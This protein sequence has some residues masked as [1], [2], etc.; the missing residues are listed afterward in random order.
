MIP[1]EKYRLLAKQLPRR[2]G[3]QFEK[4][5]PT[6]SPMAIDLLRKLLTFDASKRITVEEALRHPFLSSL[7]FPDDE[8]LSVPVQRLDFEFE[9][10]NL[11][12]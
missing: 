6:A 8:P 2:P 5:F 10:Y 9:E 1:R 3:K 12:L 11:T 4:L 7:H